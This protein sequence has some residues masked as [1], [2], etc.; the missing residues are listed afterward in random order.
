M[1]TSFERSVNT[2]VEWLTPPELVKKLGEFDLDPCSPVNA[3]FLHAKHNYTIEDN[4]LNKEWFG[5]VFCNPPYGKDTTP[6]WLAKLKK[7]GNGIALIYARTE[8]KYFFEN[9]WDDADALLFVKGRIRFYHVSGIQGGTPGAPS[10]FVAY[11]RENAKALK[12][13][14]IEG[15]YLDL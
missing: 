6:L 2:K 7:H 15:R 5:R 1:D 12:E 8:T 10:V 14:G 9:I 13:S 3:P 11:G 4:G